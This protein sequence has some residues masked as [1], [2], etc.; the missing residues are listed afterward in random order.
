MHHTVPIGPYFGY[1]GKATFLLRILVLFIAF[2]FCR[3][4]SVL[5]FK[6]KAHAQ[7]DTIC[8]GQYSQLSVTIQGGP[9][10]FTY[11]WSPPATLSDP[12]IS[13]PIATPL[14][15]TMYHVLVTDQFSNI[16]RDSITVYVET[17]PPPPSHIFGPDNVCSDTVCYYS[18]TA[19]T[20]ANSYS[21]TVP[22]GA[23]IL[24]GQNTDS[25]ELKWGT[26]SGTVSVIIA[27]NCGTS[28]PSVLSVNVTVIPPEPGQIQGLSHLCHLDTTVYKIDTLRAADSYIWSFPDGVII[29]SGTGTNSVKV[30]WGEVSG[31]VSVAGRNSCGTGPPGTKTVELDSL[32]LKAGKINGPDTVCAGKEDYNYFISP[33]N[34]ATS[35]EWSLPPGAVISS[36]LKTNRIS[37]DFSDTASS[38]ILLVYGLNTCGAGESSSQVITLR[39]CTGTDEKELHSKLIISPNP[40]SEKMTVNISGTENQFYLFIYDVSG[41]P[42]F[43]K[44]LSNI[45]P[46]FDYELNASRFPGGI[47]YLR[48]VNEHG[49]SGVKF[50]V[51]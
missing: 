28:I 19:A 5:A 49:A 17:I 10:P 12:N 16:S 7:P 25:I 23:V 15:N 47:Y 46:S 45:P 8:Q 51:R 22:T 48:I 4:S 11:L 40:V 21:W 34:F 32:P 30:I 39:K 14:V 50:I 9:G 1:R 2:T 29:L 42:V 33:V 24:S 35:Y 18:V 13:N 44:F 26:V 31:D 38:G 43:S 37:I 20:D 27:N 6:A 36:G 3:G 41:K